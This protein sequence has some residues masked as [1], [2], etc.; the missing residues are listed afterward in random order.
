MRAEFPPLYGQDR[1]SAAASSTSFTTAPSK[2]SRTDLSEAWRTPSISRV[3]IEP[4]IFYTTF[5]YTMNYRVD[6][7]DVAWA[8]HIHKLEFT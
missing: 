2:S 7:S 5:S 1:K 8:A 4:S 6:R 3:E